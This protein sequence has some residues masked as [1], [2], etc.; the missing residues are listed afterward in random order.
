MKDRDVMNAV[1]GG[2]DERAF[3]VGAKG[4]GAG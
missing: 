2:T 1:F 4:F 3:D